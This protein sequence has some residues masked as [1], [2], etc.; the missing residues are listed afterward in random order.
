MT[1][2]LRLKLHLEKFIR[3]YSDVYALEDKNPGHLS[4]N[5]YA[6]EIFCMNFYKN[7]FES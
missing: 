3:K 7:R 2:N 1:Q 4:S 5:A 6:P